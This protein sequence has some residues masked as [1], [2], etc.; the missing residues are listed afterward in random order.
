MTK[1][2]NNIKTGSRRKSL[3]QKITPQ[4]LEGLP[5]VGELLLVNYRVLLFEYLNP[6]NV[7]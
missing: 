7:V 6:F 2:P 4:F 3:E 5:K 1:M